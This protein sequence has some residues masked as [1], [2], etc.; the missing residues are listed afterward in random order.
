MKRD[1]LK[2]LLLTSTML[3][4]SAAI[5]ADRAMEMVSNTCAGCH[6]TNGES[7]GEAPVIAG[8]PETYLKQAM[9]SYK[10]GTRYSTVMGR[11]AKGYDAKQ[12]ELMAKFFAAKPWKSVEQETDP[13]KVKKG[14]ALHNSLGCMGCHGVNGVSPIP[15]T[16]RLAGQYADYLYLQLTDYADPE[17]PIP[18]AAGV[19]RSA[20]KGKSSEDLEALAQF[21]A[22]QK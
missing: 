13:A 16:P 2:T 4:G 19:M 15:T 9:T 18:P 12:F 14:Q 17:K 11:I 20:L 21:Y 5:A 7:V 1:Y 6:N 10:D 22:S 3:A 8:L